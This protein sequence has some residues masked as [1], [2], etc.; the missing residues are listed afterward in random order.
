MNRV[1]RECNKCDDKHEVRYHLYKDGSKHLVCICP[2]YGY[3]ALKFEDGLD[4]SYYKTSK[5][6]V[7]AQLNGLLDLLENTD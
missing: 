5:V 3:T 6:K 7:R 2:S 4:L 1:Y